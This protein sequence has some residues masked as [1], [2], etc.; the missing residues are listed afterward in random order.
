MSDY[1]MWHKRFVS[2][3]NFLGSAAC[4]MEQAVFEDRNN[5][6]FSALLKRMRTLIKSVDNQLARNFK[7]IR[8]GGVR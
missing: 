5:P 2:A 6:Q 3:R 7:R 4:E 8:K 1:P